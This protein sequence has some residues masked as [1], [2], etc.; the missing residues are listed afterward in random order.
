MRKL[1]ALAALV[2]ALVTA[3]GASA[4]AHGQPS[5]QHHPGTSFADGH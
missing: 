5:Y 4:A 1:A 2:V 3:T